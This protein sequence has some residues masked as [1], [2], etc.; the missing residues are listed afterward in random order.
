MFLQSDAVQNLARD[1]VRPTDQVIYSTMDTGTS[2]FTAIVQEL[3]RKR[4]GNVE[5][6]AATPELLMVSSSS[7]Y[8]LISGKSIV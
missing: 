5:T 1:C 7:N 4:R 6:V 8:E 3:G 2:V